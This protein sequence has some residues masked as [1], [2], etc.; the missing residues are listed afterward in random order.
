MTDMR[1][2]WLQQ[3]SLAVKEQDVPRLMMIA[4]L[5]YASGF[6]DEYVCALIQLQLYG[7][8]PMKRLLDQ[9]TSMPGFEPLKMRFSTPGCP[10]SSRSQLIFTVADWLERHSKV[11]ASILHVTPLA[12]DAWKFSNFGVY[13]SAINGGLPKDAKCIQP[14]P[15]PTAE[16][17]VPNIA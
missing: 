5:C 15:I 2:S 10:C 6:M 14:P 7:L 8:L 12:M 4:R 1:S 11:I 13:I 17:L 16:T 3:I 9:L